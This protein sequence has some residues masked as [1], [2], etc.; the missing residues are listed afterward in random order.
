MD[1]KIWS[2]LRAHFYSLLPT[3]LL[4]TFLLQTPF[5]FR[6]WP[7][8]TP[9]HSISSHF[10]NFLAFEVQLEMAKLEDKNCKYRDPNAPIEARVQDLLSRMTLREKVGQMT[11]I[12]RRVATPESIRDFAIGNPSHHLL[13][14]CYCNY[15]NFTKFDY[16]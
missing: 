10:F 9:L 4:P 12:E 8:S 16:C 5:I 11:Q 1:S 14:F 7:I 3:F 13:L 15:C 2:Q 6:G